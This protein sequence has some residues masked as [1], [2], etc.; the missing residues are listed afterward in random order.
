MIL[1]SQDTELS[2]VLNAA[3]AICAAARTAPKACAIDHLDTAVLTDADKDKLTAE[4]RKI[5]RA[6]GERGKFFI[7]D[8]D[9]TDK[10]QAV[11]LIGAKYE[12]RRLGAMCGLCGFKN[13]SECTEAGAACVFTAMD[14]GIALGSAVS[15]AAD[16]RIDN[17]IMFTV[18]KAAAA[19]GLLGEY[20]MIIGIPLSVSGKTPFFDRERI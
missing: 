4:M 3:N 11:V 12:T 17:R 14:L 9:N 1:K 7:R 5:G 13:C 2:A 19:I 16:L 15:I 18:G 6:I 8:A 20:K 10:A